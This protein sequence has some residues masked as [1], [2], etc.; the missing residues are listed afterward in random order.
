MNTYFTVKKHSNYCISLGDFLVP[1]KLITS[2]I[3]LSNS[4]KYYHI[5]PPSGDFKSRNIQIRQGFQN[6]CLQRHTY[7][8]NLRD[9]SNPPKFTWREMILNEF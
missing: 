6:F 8:L 2:L 7:V 5:T 4:S 3:Y 1:I 9:F